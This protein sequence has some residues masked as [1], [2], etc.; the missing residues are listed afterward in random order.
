MDYKDELLFTGERIKDLRKAKG[1]TIQEL[2]Y[3]SELERSSLSEIEAGKTNMT[4]R[5]LCKVAKGLG[6]RISALVR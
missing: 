3:R 5:I 2:A 1:W 4:F 6:V